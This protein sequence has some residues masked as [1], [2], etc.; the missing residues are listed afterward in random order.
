[1]RVGEMGNG[2]NWATARAALPSIGLYSPMLLIKAAPPDWYP[3]PFRGGQGLA[4]KVGLGHRS[5]LAGAYHL[6]EF[7][8]DDHGS[9]LACASPFCSNSMEMLSGERTKAMRPSRGGRLMVTPAF[10]RRSQV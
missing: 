5:A 3:A 6:P 10:I 9:F 8:I 7:G 2:L 4:S 1:R